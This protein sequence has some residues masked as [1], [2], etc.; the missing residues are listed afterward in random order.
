MPLEQ[1][2]HYLPIMAI[3]AGVLLLAWSQRDRI[4]GLLTRFKPQ[5]IAQPQAE[6]QTQSELSP[7]ERF[8]MVFA[9]RTWCLAAGHSE[10]VKALDVQVLPA[11]VQNGG[12]KS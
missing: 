2:T 1:L 10:A 8:A 3:A 9:L 5:P 6:P 4:V 7:A 12:T 11:I